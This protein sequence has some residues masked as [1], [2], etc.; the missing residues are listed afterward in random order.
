[1]I[2]SLG[3]NIKAFRKNKGFTQEELAG[4]LN[5]TPQAVSRWESEVGMPDVAMLIPLAQSLGVSTD[6][7]L[8]YDMIREDSEVTTRIKET[9]KNMYDDKDRSGSK[10]KICEYLSTE[11]NIHPGNYEIVKDYVQETASL[12]MYW[13]EKLEGCY[14]DQNDHI[15]DIFKDSIKKGTYLISHCTDRELIDKT[16]YAIAW[17]YIHMKDFDK[18]KEHINV[19]PGLNSTCNREVLEMETAFFDKGFDSMK[20]VIDNKNRLLFSTIARQFYTVAQNYGW[21]GEKDEAVK[22]ISWCDDIID[23]F[24]TRLDA[25]DKKDYMHIKYMN[26]FHKMIALKRAGEDDK[27]AEVYSAFV[28]EV[29]SMDDIS[30]ELKKESIAILDREIG[31]YGK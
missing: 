2:N 13:D 22:I 14:K 1:M 16:H 28:D 6:A 27:A 24:A 5:V 4:L 11:T 20:E 9:V 23:S 21:W 18:A 19:L 29:N 15:L 3:N 12:S 30:D 31:Y 10:L 26:A 17:I 7:L 25:I 8:G